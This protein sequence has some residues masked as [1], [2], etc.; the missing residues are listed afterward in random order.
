MTTASSAARNGAT[1]KPVI[2]SAVRPAA[3]SERR[4]NGLRDMGFLLGARRIW[5]SLERHLPIAI[6]TGLP[7]AQDTRQRAYCYRLIHTS[8]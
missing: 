5:R 3:K 4:L 2:A 1:A 8:S 6:G 7:D